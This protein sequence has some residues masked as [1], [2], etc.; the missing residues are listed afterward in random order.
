METGDNIISD[1]YQTETFTIAKLLKALLS[2]SNI[3]WVFRDLNIFW[4]FRDLNIFCMF[5]DLKD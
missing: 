1:N 3:F 2:M 4:V 5:R